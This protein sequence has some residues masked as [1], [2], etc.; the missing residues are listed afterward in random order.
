MDKLNVYVRMHNQ[1]YS[2]CLSILVFLVCRP[3][4][5][6]DITIGMS[7]AFTGPSASLGIELYRGASTYLNYIVTTQV[8]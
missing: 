8:G 4:A 1:R 2:I 7:A 6:S 5:A 3:A